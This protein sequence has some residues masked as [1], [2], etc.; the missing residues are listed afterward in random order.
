M[1]KLS[2]FLCTAVA[3]MGLS[4]SALAAPS[5]QEPT[6]VRPAP[7]P[8]APSTPAASS[9][10][11]APAQQAAPAAPAQQAAPSTP[12]AQPDLSGSVS[13][14]PGFTVVPGAEFIP[15]EGQT[16]ADFE[17]WQFGIL[18]PDDSRYSNDKVKEIATNVNDPEVAFDMAE[19]MDVLEKEEEA[20]AAEAQEEKVYRT[21]KGTIIDPREYSLSTRFA[22]LAMAKG[23]LIQ[24][25]MNEKSVKVICDLAFDVLK[26]PKSPTGYTDQKVLKR[27]AK[28]L[29]LVIDP[30]TA[31]PQFIEIEPENFERET[32]TVRK[33]EFNGVGLI[34]IIEKD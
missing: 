17:G 16:A 21:N 9:T 30:I 15:G 6:P 12:A 4:V 26:M 29:I 32:G 33:I 24:Y 18:D 7:A 13:E 8:S 14:T 28:T 23:A 22:E 20:D 1:R 19:I 11:A 5:P 31:E 25:Q 34:A 3:V 27:L 10:P 2:V